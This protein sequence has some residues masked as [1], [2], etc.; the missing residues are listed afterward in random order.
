MRTIIIL[1]LI[2]LVPLSALA[3]KVAVLPVSYWLVWKNAESV[4][5]AKAIQEE[6]AEGA[7]EAGFEVLRGAEVEDAVWSSAGVKASD[8]RD[9]EC[10]S[11][12]AEKLGVENALFV[13]I[14]EEGL[15]YNVEVILAKGE[16]ESGPLGGNFAKL[17]KGVRSM[18]KTVLQS[19]KKEPEPEATP[20]PSIETETE[21]EP[22]PTT[23]EQAESKGISP[24]PFYITAGLTSAIAITYVVTESVGYA[25]YNKLEEGDQDDWENKKDALKPLQTTSRVFM[26]LTV[27]GAIATTVLFFLTD[28]DKD[29]STPTAKLTPVPT[30]G[31][32]LLM[33]NGRF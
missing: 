32:G 7:F 26:G 12:V 20:P 33:L 25:R 1:I 30:D 9:S 24:I 14:T 10:L 6:V 29:E 22:E 28:F 18:V 23:E 31:G 15:L 17:K 3:Q 27:A 13:S 4:E 5:K 11:S 19:T 2:Y 8:C 16:A 21:P